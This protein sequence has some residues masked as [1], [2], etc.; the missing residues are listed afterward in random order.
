MF[1]IV[2]IINWDILHEWLMLQESRLFI[3]IEKKFS[4]SLRTALWRR[5]RIYLVRVLFLFDLFAELSEFREWSAFR[6]ILKKKRVAVPHAFLRIPECTTRFRS[7][8]RL[9]R[10]VINLSSLTIARGI[11]AGQDSYYS[12]SCIHS[13]G[14]SCASA[15]RA[16]AR[17]SCVKGAERK[18][19]RGCRR[20]RPT[21]IESFM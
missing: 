5:S 8:R 21:G 15:A 18:R 3:E 10:G 13:L 16:R 9:R 20:E 7:S 4:I 12:S 14:S 11:T 17:E 19:E 1:Q 2:R 6:S